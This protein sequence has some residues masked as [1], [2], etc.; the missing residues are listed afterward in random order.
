MAAHREEVLDVFRAKGLPDE[1]ARS[2]RSA[3]LIRTRC[4]KPRHHEDLRLGPARMNSCDE[5]RTRGRR[6]VKIEQDVGGRRGTHPIKKRTP[7]IES[8]R[9]VTEL[10]DQPT[11]GAA[12]AWIVIDYGDEATLMFHRTAG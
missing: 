12:D 4:F 1:E 11:Q 3:G 7:G 2:R 8:Q 6:H 5:R 10:A 9:V